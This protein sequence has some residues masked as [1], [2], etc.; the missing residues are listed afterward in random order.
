MEPGG[1]AQA[2]GASGELLCWGDGPQ[3]FLAE[4]L[5]PLTGLSWAGR[6]P[7]SS[8]RS[9]LRS[10]E[11][12]LHWPPFRLR[13]TPLHTLP[14]LQDSSGSTEEEEGGATGGLGSADCWGT[15]HRGRSLSRPPSQP[16]GAPLHRGCSHWGVLAEEEEGWVVTVKIGRAHV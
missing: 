14:G 11:S 6:S 5:R 8:S 15:S 7:S 13:S 2:D 1:H 4:L 9:G 10:R 12:P 16:S 3:T